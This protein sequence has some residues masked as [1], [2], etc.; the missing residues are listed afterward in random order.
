MNRFSVCTLMVVAVGTTWGSTAL[1]VEPEAARKHWAFQSLDAAKVPVVPNAPTLSAVDRFIV[2]ELA[3]KRLSLSPAAE[4]HTLIRRVTFD[5]T[6]LPPTPDEISAFVNDKD[7]AAFDRVLDRLLASPRYGERWG[8]L[9]LDV[10]GYADSNG[11]FN[12]DS[13]RPL[14]YR[15]RDYVIRSWNDDKPFDQF[16]REQ[17]A[18]DE[19]ARLESG[20]VTPHTVDLLTATHFLRNSQDG[21]SESDGN[22]DEVLQDRFTALEGT[23]QITVNALLGLTIQCARCHDHKFEPIS[24]KE[25]YELQSIFYPAFPTF[26]PEKWVKPRD[27]T[28]HVAVPAEQQ[29]YEA[30][31]QAHEAEVEALKHTL[32]EWEEKNRPHGT[33]LFADP[34]D[35]KLADRWSNTAPGDDV[36]GGS[37]AVQL[38]PEV[39]DA[40]VA[41]ATVR[42]GHLSILESGAAGDR[43]LSTRQV[44]DWTPDVVGASVQVTF[45][46]VADR[47]EG[48]DPAA[49][50][51]FFLALHDFNDNSTDA[52]AGNIL[53]DG[54]PAGGAALH[55]DYPGTDARA[56]GTVGEAG[57]QA[58]RNYG[59]RISRTK[60][61][62]F[63]V[64]HLVG[65]HPEGPT[66]ILE[67]SDLPNGG[68]GF[69]YC[70]KRSFVVDNVLV[71]Q[72]AGEP[73]AE[74]AKVAEKR[75]EL[76]AA[77]AA[78]QAAKPQQPGLMAWTTDL[79]DTPKTWL[80]GRGNYK[81]HLEPV[82]PGILS[83]VNDAPFVVEPVTGGKPVSELPDVSTGRRLAFARWLTAP[84]TRASALVARVL[85]NR[86]WQQH[87]GVGLVTSSDNFGL[88]GSR[89]V[90]PE[91]LNHL[92]R[93]LVTN[94][95]KLK[96]LHRTILQ[97]AAYQQQSLPRTEARKV[98][99]DN[100]LWWRYPPRRL[101]AEAL[102]D[103]MLFV[104]GELQESNGGPYTPTTRQADGEVI[105]DEPAGDAAK[106]VLRRSVYLQQRRSQVNSL[107]EL[108]DAPT[109]VT[110]CAV[111]P[112]STVPLQSLALLNSNFV[113]SRA[114]ALA[115]KIVS[116]DRTREEQV[117]AAFQLT[118]GRNPL[119]AEQTA[120][121][122]FLTSQAS[123]YPDTPDRTL[124]VWTD[125]CQML[126][127]SNA[128][129][130]VD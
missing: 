44:F 102:R 34:F 60:E 112:S 89:P 15:Y 127:A 8:K 17:L 81:D 103:A 30:A 78:K 35:D 31:M 119:P 95:W 105:V 75:K 101:E 115:K 84:D 80:L 48:S 108:F 72:F 83:A 46:L 2:A 13:D 25:Y 56:A 71:E 128:F 123:E 64:Q 77:V 68:F 9:W 70:C 122:Q 59:V 85:V 39:G 1:A 19:L 6:G 82:G 62:K 24:H 65:G 28:A 99:P 61:D 14:A 87:F 58:G 41:A 22:A 110:N 114:T 96:S 50:I 43:W 21:T 66:V 98:D 74:L 32:S 100:R 26:N 109:I 93:E 63:L 40:A 57:Y 7:P 90:H 47:I 42:D 37:P 67:A 92:A 111:R 16:L 129:L 91:L 124:L 79:M 52:D 18:G 12:A 86:I 73:A 20:E 5:L 76:A 11:Y 120:T 29:A 117:L 27:R 53:F 55:I 97:S 106:S 69:E 10:V 121:V 36:E 113:R 118:V 107:L 130:Y 23:L 3:K 4:R 104:S 38:E 51:G 116:P 125:A 33:V 45:D 88:S 94:G 126:L 54:N 49:R